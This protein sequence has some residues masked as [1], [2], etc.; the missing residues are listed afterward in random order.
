MDQ[1]DTMC[2]ACGKKN[3]IGLKLEFREEDNQYITVFTP[4]EEHQGYPGITHGGITAAV[5]DEVCARF[6][7]AQGKIAFTA[8]I[9]VRYRKGIP[10]GKQVTFISRIIRHR[11][12]LYE[13]SGRAIL[14]DGSVAAEAEAKV[15]EA[16]N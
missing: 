8:A 1:Y 7:Y 2:F 4:G 10:I 13:V 15:M 6:I 16:K 9:N 5:L 14:E 11:G 3:P 12:R